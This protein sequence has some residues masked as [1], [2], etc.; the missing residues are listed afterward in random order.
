MRFFIVLSFLCMT[1]LGAGC[2]TSRVIKD[3]SAP[4]IVIDKFGDVTFR[5]KRVEPDKIVS[6]VKSAKI[7]K[8]TKIWILVP[9]NCD[10]HLMGRVAGH[11]AS[12]GYW[13]VFVTDRKATLDIM[14]QP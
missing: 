4:E 10:R 2:T 14:S 8:T 12:A 11:L 6:A 3:S 5:G 13:T 1:I 9:D 7:S